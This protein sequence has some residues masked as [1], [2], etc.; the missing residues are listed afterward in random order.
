MSPRPDRPRL[1]RPRLNTAWYLARNGRFRLIDRLDPVWSTIVIS[2][3]S[4]GIILGSLTAWISGAREVDEQVLDNRLLH[5]FTK[6]ACF[7]SVATD[8]DGQVWAALDNRDDCLSDIAD[9]G[10]APY[11]PVWRL[12]GDET[13]PFAGDAGASD[14]GTLARYSDAVWINGD[15]DG[16]AVLQGTEW[17]VWLSQSS[18]VVDGRPMRQSD[19]SVA[20]SDPTQRWTVLATKRGV[21]GLYDSQNGQWTILGQ[22]PSGRRPLTDLVWSANKLWATDSIGLWHMELAP[23]TPPSSRGAFAEVSKQETISLSRAPDGGVLALHSVPCAEESRTNPS[24]VAGCQMLVNYGPDGTPRQQLLNNADRP[25]G[26]RQ[27]NVAF[28]ATIGQQI[29]LAGDKG[30]TLYDPTRRTWTR[31]E[32]EPVFFMATSDRYGIALA[33]EDSV[34]WLTD[35]TTRPLRSSIPI[36]ESSLELNSLTFD[37][38]GRLLVGRSDGVLFEVPKSGASTIVFQPSAPTTTDAVELAFSSDRHDVFITRRMLVVRDRES[39]RYVTRPAD[40]NINAIRMSSVRST[41][42]QTFFAFSA[43]RSS[44]GHIYVLDPSRPDQILK[45]E[46]VP[47]VT[48]LTKLSEGEVAYTTASG[49]LFTAAV[50]ESGLDITKHSPDAAAGGPR[51]EQIRDVATFDN[52]LAFATERGVVQY[53]AARRDWRNIWRGNAMALTPGPGQSLLSVTDTGALQQSRPLSNSRWSTDTLGQVTQLPHSD[54]TQLH[55]TRVADNGD[56]VF[57]GAPGERAAAHLTIYRPSTREIISTRALNRVGK[58]RIEDY[59]SPTEWLVSVDGR[60]ITAWRALPLASGSSGVEGG[61]VEAEGD[62]IV[63]LERSSATG[64]LF[65]HR[66][67]RTGG[68]ARCLYRGMTLRR[69]PGLAAQAMSDTHVV[70]GSETGVHLLDRSAQ[71]WFESGLTPG[72]YKLGLRGGDLWATPVDDPA[73]LFRVDV[74]R[75]PDF[76]TCSEVR[77]AFTPLAYRSAVVSMDGSTVTEFAARTGVVTQSLEGQERRTLLAPS[78]GSVVFSGAPMRVLRAGDVLWVAFADGLKRYSLSERSWL[79]VYRVPARDWDQVLLRPGTGSLRGKIVASYVAGSDWLQIVSDRSGGVA[80]RSTGSLQPTPVLRDLSALGTLQNVWSMSDYLVFRFQNRLTLLS[81]SSNTWLSGWPIRENEVVLEVG[82]RH[83]LWSERDRRI[84]FQSN[85]SPLGQR[86]SVTIPARATPLIA[87]SGLAAWTEDN[88]RVVECLSDGRCRDLFEP[89]PSFSTRDVVG[90][91]RLAQDVL[92]EMRDGQVVRMSGRQPAPI[93]GVVLENT[94]DP[95][96]RYRERVG[97]FWQSSDKSRIWMHLD[98]RDHFVEGRTLTGSEFRLLD[99]IESGEFEVVSWNDSASLSVNGILRAPGLQARLPESVEV[100]EVRRIGRLGQLMWFQREDNLGIIDPSCTADDE[101]CHKEKYLTAPDRAIAYLT[102]NDETLR[103]TLVDGTR[104]QYEDGAW[105][106]LDPIWQPRRVD[107]SKILAEITTRLPNGTST[108]EETA[109]V[110][111]SAD[112][113]SAVITAPSGE[114]PPRVYTTIQGASPNALNHDWLRFDPSRRVFEVGA[115]GSATVL[116]TDQAFARDGRFFP[117]AISAPAPQSDGRVLAVTPFGQ[118]ASQSRAPTTFSMTF[119]PANIRPGSAIGD[120]GGHW[121]GASFQPLGQPPR[122]AD[123]TLTTTIGAFS[124]TESRLAP[125]AKVLLGRQQLWSNEIGFLWDGTTDIGI[126]ANDDIYTRTPVGALPLTDPTRGPVTTRLIWTGQMMSELEKPFASQESDLTPTWQSDARR[127]NLWVQGHALLGAARIGRGILFSTD[128]GLALGRSL[129]L[130]TTLSE[131]GTTPSVLRY[132]PRIDAMLGETERATVVLDTNN[133]QTRSL[134]AAERAK[135]EAE[136]LWRF[137]PLLA[138]PDGRG[139]ALLLASPSQLQKALD[140]SNRFR[141]DTTLNIKRNNDWF[142]SL[143]PGL[144]ARGRVPHPP[145]DQ[146]EL[147]WNAPATT[148][149]DVVQNAGTLMLWDGPRQCGVINGDGRITR[150]QPTA[151]MRSEI[152]MTSGEGQKTLKAMETVGSWQFSYRGRKGAY[153][154]TDLKKGSFGFDRYISVA[155]CGDAPFAVDRDARIVSLGAP[156]AWR[157]AEPTTQRRGA[158]QLLCVDRERIPELPAGPWVGSSFGRLSLLVPEQSVS[159]Q[160]VRLAE[161]YFGTLLPGASPPEPL[162]LMRTTSTQLVLETRGRLSE[163]QIFRS[164]SVTPS[165]V[166]RFTYRS[167]TAAAIDQ[168]SLFFHLGNTLWAVTPDGVAPYGSA[169]RARLTPSQ[170]AVWALPQACDQAVRAWQRDANHVV[171][172]CHNGETIEVTGTVQ[173][174]ANMQKANEL[175]QLQTVGDL[176]VVTRHGAGLIEASLGERHRSLVLFDGGFTFDQISDARVSDDQRS[177]HLATR[178]GWYG[179]AINGSALDAGLDVTRNAAAHQ[180]RDQLAGLTRIRGLSQATGDSDTCVTDGREAW[181]VSSDMRRPVVTSLGRTA[182]DHRQAQDRLRI[183]L[184]AADT[185]AYTLEV[186]LQTENVPD[187]LKEGRFLS[188]R[189]DGSPS[190]DR[191]NQ[192]ETFCVRSRLDGV[193]ISGSSKAANERVANAACVRRHLKAEP[194][195]D[196][197]LFTVH[198]GELMRRYLP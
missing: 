181:L 62:Y 120:E 137:G 154:G 114:W 119:S 157:L 118:L 188:D 34:T 19:I 183:H 174:V 130:P 132:D 68:Q 141:F 67:A 75:R 190:L 140:H 164:E 9:G 116:R 129:K 138:R 88:G 160:Q 158:A 159:A 74:S 92:L 30:A 121:I 106:D 180:L 57:V 93:Q 124:S 35:S 37:S 76:D 21:L 105:E 97:T 72:R 25:K 24:A 142:V 95:L 175:D 27:S 77:T 126:D 85:S 172:L 89:P 78:R 46:E 187:T 81:L 198:D 32:N 178:S 135:I 8:A 3:L 193:S 52:G 36:S 194:I 38:S 23:G 28:S 168:P 131:A 63:T 87:D 144:L 16:L 189:A 170:G 191:V 171:L 123:S 6:E 14:A 107:H 128:G 2:V 5:S 39:R 86:T 125:G 45:S 10:V 99:A 108:F 177:L 56:L 100:G 79:D 13:T 98:G 84:T 41:K 48:A 69:T 166:T 165:S 11:N 73:A 139:I 179:T 161:H 101:T 197:S 149:L 173:P 112:G 151:S 91:S 156:P 53:D 47:T 43:A 113:A 61:W 49:D 54:G 147:I 122:R 44:A 65:L 136:P 167:T 33:L 17:S 58:A 163:E 133:L 146:L 20:A 102:G 195:A 184:R 150:C 104:L 60:A 176:R 7:E 83:L 51:P 109:Q 169:Y 143:H 145:L 66:H 94:S 80:E 96:R 153:L 182:C 29:L 26:W 42:G 64:Q 115:E 134:T 31:I 103:A 196:H 117:L 155:S 152:T 186:V 185:G 70:A 192:A 1:R 4:G 82:N 18:F 71:R 15:N 148:S 127:A 110:R 22:A 111:L 55:D 40:N 162:L 12:W 50:R 90:A 59:R